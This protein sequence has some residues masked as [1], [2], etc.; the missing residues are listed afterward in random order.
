MLPNMRVWDK[1]KIEAL[2]PLHVANRIIETPLINVVEDDKLLW[3]DSID[4]NYSVKSGY[5]VVMNDTRRA[6][7]LEH[8]GDWLGLWKIKAP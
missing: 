3:S 2:F 4:G 8:N 6:G 1:E 5:K 7:D